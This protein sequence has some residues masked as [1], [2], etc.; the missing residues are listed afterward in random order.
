MTAGS[1][2]CTVSSEANTFDLRFESTSGK[3]VTSL[4]NRSVG[5]AWS[6]ATA[7]PKQLEDTS[8]LKHYIF[9]QTTLGVGEKIFGLGERFTEF[10]KRGQSVT[11]YNEDG[12]TSSEQAYKNIPFYLSSAGYG[13]FIDHAESLDLEIG[14]ERSCRLQVSAE[15]Q[16]LKWFIIYGPTPK[17]ILRKYAFLTGF[18]PRLPSW[19]YGLWLS[20]SFTTD[21]DEKTVTSFLDGM[22][23]RN[24]PVSVFHFDCFWLR[25]FHWCDFIFS[26]KDFPNPKEMMTRIKKKYPN[27]KISAWINPYI[28]DASPVFE[29]AAGKGY[30]VKREN[31][32]V[33]QWDLWQAGMGLVDFTNPAACRWFELKLETLFDIGIDCLKTDFGER[34][35]HHLLMDGLW[36]VN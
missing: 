27:I 15:T 36:E 32:D 12:G 25:P 3:K 7:S 14:S 18:A 5:Y 6:P 17:D 20:T 4:S 30:L 22:H 8:N 19:S 35:R 34:V 23:E 2:Q 10:N 24:L 9:T 21:Y 31:G 1:L 26:E 29:E 13:V 16:R 33:W 11:L 28:G